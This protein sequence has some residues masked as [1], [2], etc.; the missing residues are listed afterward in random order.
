MAFAAHSAAVGLTAPAA[1]ASTLS[2]RR[3]SRTVG[4]AVIHSERRVVRAGI[5]DNFGKSDEAA[6]DAEF[7]RQQEVLAARRSGKAVE[8]ALKRRAKLKEDMSDP[9]KR[10]AAYN[11]VVDSK[12]IPGGEYVEKGWVEETEGGGLDVGGILRK[13]FQKDSKKK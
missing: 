8:G 4:R 9:K 7:Q 1:A 5:F 12:Y 10:E 3:R 11:K 2:L 13:I 6:K